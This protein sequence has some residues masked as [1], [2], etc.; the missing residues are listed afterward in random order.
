VRACRPLLGT[1][2]EIRVEHPD[3]DAATVAVDAGFAAISRVQRLM[4]V[5]DPDSDLGRINRLADREP[6]AVDPWTREVLELA[7][8]LHMESGGL[9]DCGVAPRPAESGLPPAPGAAPPG[10]TLANLHFTDDGRVAFGAPTR[11]DLGGIAKGYA[12][13]RAAAAILAAGANGG[14]INAGG[15]LRVVG[16]AEEAIHLRDPGNPQRLHF[17]GLLRD[18]ACATSA[19]YYSRRRHA[20]R[21]VSALVDPRTRRPLATRQSFTVI[22]PRCA[23]ADAL[24]KVL[25]VSGDPGLPCFSRYGAHPLILSQSRVRHDPSQT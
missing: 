2:V 23:V 14:T 7:L 21:E 13:D 17:A 19:T 5:F 25:A 16:A 9:F 11:L 8:A 3:A 4:S 22:A 12:V 10:S 18:G 6:V 24:T 1:Y 20:G 15:D